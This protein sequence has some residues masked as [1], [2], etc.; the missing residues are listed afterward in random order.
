M[1]NLSPYF[2][3]IIISVSSALVSLIV[4]DAY[5]IDFVVRDKQGGLV[6][7]DQASTK[8][9]FELG[10]LAIPVFLANIIFAVLLIFHYKNILPNIIKNS[11]KFIREFEVSRRISAII[12][13]SLLI[14]FISSH[15]NEI[16]HSKEEAWG[17]YAGTYKAVKNWQGIHLDNIT[18]SFK[19]LLLG[20]SLNLLGNIRIIPFITSIALLILTYFFINQITKKRFAGIISMA[21]IIQSSLFAN[22]SATATYENFWIFFYL[23]SLYVVN[24][25]WYFSPIFY[26]LSLFCKPLTTIFLPMTLFFIY[27]SKIPKREFRYSIISYSIIG[28]SITSAILLGKSSAGGLE[29]HAKE[30]LTGF[31]SFSIYLRSDYFIIL[32]LIPLVICLYLASRRDIFHSKSIMILISGILLSTPLLSGFTDITNQPYRLVPLVVFFAMGVGILFS[33]RREETSASS[34]IV[35]KITFVFTLATVLISTLF[36]IFPAAT[37]Y[38]YR[39]SL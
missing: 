9:Q 16:E 3:I 20:I 13:A 1:V 15:I 32:F 12:V 34:K 23:L 2:L 11:I 31:N 24:K 6:Y 4:N 27:Y 35:S 19:Y 39:L 25:R 10:V 18:T 33:N 26:I 21:V 38:Y 7:S 30:F 28:I 36:M 29:Y 14:I 22:Y 5:A 17:D 37:P 8:N